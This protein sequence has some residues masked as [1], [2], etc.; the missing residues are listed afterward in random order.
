MLGGLLWDGMLR[1]IW[2]KYQPMSDSDLPIYL[3]AIN[4]VSKTRSIEEY[5]IEKLP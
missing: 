5:L 3:V 4:F 2:L 1:M